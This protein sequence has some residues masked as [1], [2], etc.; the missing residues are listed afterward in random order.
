MNGQICWMNYKAVSNEGG[1]QNLFM[2]QRLIEMVNAKKHDIF[3][4]FGN[5]EKA[6]YDRVSA[7]RITLSLL[8]AIASWFLQFINVIF[9]L[10][11]DLNNACMF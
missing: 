3:V 11:K 2:L 5:I 10:Y 1:I 7:I 6:Y 8:C 4:A 9:L